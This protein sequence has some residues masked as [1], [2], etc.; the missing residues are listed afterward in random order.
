MSVSEAD[1]SLDHKLSELS[2]QLPL[3][4]LVTPTNV[5]EAWTTFLAGEEPVFAYRAMP[6]LNEIS[7]ALDRLT[8]EEATD[9]TIAHMAEGVIRELK[10]KVELLSR[11]N[12]PDFFLTS[13][14]MFGH[15]DDETLEAANRILG[16]VPE[17]KST[18]S[19][20]GATKLAAE[21]LKELDYYQEQFPEMVATVNVSSTTTGSYT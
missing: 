5:T 2:G 20:V 10:L 7:R 21:A 11:R 16:L 6:D 3:L 8:S 1:L 18:R 14:E 9:P 19:R 15:V 4:R 17:D 13:V 12:S